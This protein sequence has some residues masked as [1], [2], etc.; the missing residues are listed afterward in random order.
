MV[1]TIHVPDVTH[2]LL[3]LAASS[4]TPWYLSNELIG[5]VV[6][7]LVGAALTF[8]LARGGLSRENSLLKTR[9][10]NLQSERDKARSELRA[11]RAEVGALRKVET[12]Y[13]EVKKILGDSSVVKDYDQPVLLLGPRNVGKTSL[14]T[15]WHAPWNS[16]TLESTRRLLTSTVPV[17]DYTQPDAA[18]HFADADVLTKVHVHLKVK[19]H[20]FPGEPH[21]Q[22][23]VAKVARSETKRLR[24]E[25]RKAL[26]VVLVCMFDAE[27]AATGVS[28]ETK[29]Y[30]NG[31]FFSHLRGFVINEAI[32]IERLVVVFNK[33][34]LLR[35]KMPGQPDDALI[36]ECITTFDPIIEPFHYMCNSERVCET[37]TVLDRDKLRLSQGASVVLGEAARGLVTTMAGPTSA[38]GLFPEGSQATRRMAARY[39]RVS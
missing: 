21:L 27:E 38:A 37:I 31:E 35:A 36:N 4:S 29:R 20:D 25:T 13:T 14:V 2:P 3:N 5:P 10:D 16:D 1:M 8:F 9:A 32:G 19:V 12:K 28:S 11:A 7:A 30:Y 6:G 22:H 26:G 18:P 39:P 24:E 23:E 34:D 33:F 17:F 15:Q